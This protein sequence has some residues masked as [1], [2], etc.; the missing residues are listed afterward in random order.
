M[1]TASVQYTGNLRTQAKHLKSGE[2]IISD[3]PIDNNGKGEAFSPTDLLSTSL[4]SC[5]ITVM[6]IAAEKRN[7]AFNNITGEI[8]KVMASD[9]R[10]VNSI[11]VKL[12]I[13]EKWSEKERKIL[14]KV[15]VNCPV[16]K[17]LSPDLKQEIEFVYTSS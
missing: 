12:I 6:G 10:R 14:E 8:T 7:I 1:I 4:A 3:A 5:M 15:G 17:S 13:D 9:P 16:A 2:E 11:K